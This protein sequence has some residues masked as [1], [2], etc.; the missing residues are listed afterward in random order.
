MT[1]VC[2]KCNEELCLEM[3]HK[4]KGGALG[5]TS[6]CKSCVSNEKKQAY[7]ANKDSKLAAMKQYYEANKGKIL[8]SAKQRYEETKDLSKC[9]EKNKK[10]YQKDKPKAL[11]RSSLR[12]AKKLNATPKWVDADERWLI[13]EAHELAS[14]RTKM[15]GFKWHVDHVIP[16]Q[17]KNVCG[18]HTIANLQ[19]IPAFEN[20]SKHNKFKD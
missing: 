14:I 6:M 18:L 8:K 12:R 15:Y 17:G 3:F 13:K 1:K 10:Q 7:I 9:R 11:E 5:L 20:L 4:K 16:L 2:T 19:V